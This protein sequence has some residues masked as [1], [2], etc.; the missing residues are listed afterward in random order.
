MATTHDSD[1]KSHDEGHD[2]THGGP[3]WPED[4]EHPVSELMAP[5]QGASSP[6]GEIEFP[7]PADQLGYEHLTTVINR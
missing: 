5:V 2:E 1:D 3:W 4:V 7:L 6:F